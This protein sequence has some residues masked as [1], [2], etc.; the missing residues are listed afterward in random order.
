MCFPPLFSG[1]FLDVFL[2]SKRIIMEILFSFVLTSKA[3]NY[4]IFVYSIFSAFVAQQRKKDII[5]C[6]L[7][8]YTHQVE[9]FLMIFF[10]ILAIHL[11]NFK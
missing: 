11:L 5:S 4:L 2:Y 7:T 8:S 10:N 3:K 1:V 9:F 6:F